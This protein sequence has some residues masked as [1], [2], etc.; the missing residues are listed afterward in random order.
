MGD[1]AANRPANLPAREARRDL[2]ASLGQLEKQNPTRAGDAGG[3]T[4]AGFGVL[5]GAPATIREYMDIYTTTGANYIVC[6]FQ[7]GNIS[8]EQAMHSVDLFASEVM[9]HY[10]DAAAVP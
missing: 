4:G 7:W 2:D 9:P 3:A 1:N 5:A 10:V 8:H 6:S